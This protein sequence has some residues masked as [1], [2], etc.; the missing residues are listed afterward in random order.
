MKTKDFSGD[1][2]YKVTDNNAR[3]MPQQ[4]QQTMDAATTALWNSWFTKSFELHVM[5]IVDVIAAEEGKLLRKALDKLRAEL[6]V[7]IDTVRKANKRG[8]MRSKK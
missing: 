5:P 8:A 3:I 4:Q 6:L 2:I 7:E 1:L